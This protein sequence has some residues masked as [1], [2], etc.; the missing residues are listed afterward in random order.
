MA[1]HIAHIFYTSTLQEI[2]LQSVQVRGGIGNNVDGV[3]GRQISED[4]VT[5]AYPV[6]YIVN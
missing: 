5:I 3:D 2:Y 1:P 6:L 4:P